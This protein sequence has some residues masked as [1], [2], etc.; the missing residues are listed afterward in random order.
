MTIKALGTNV[1]CKVHDDE[2]R[3]TTGGLF[4]PSA[5]RGRPDRAVVE[6]CGPDAEVKPGDRICFNPYRLK[7]VFGHGQLANAQG[8]PIANPGERFVIDEDEILFIEEP[9]H[10]EKQT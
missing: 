7:V 10:A 8:S 4:I 5:T 9:E 6:H 3:I 1:F 2:Q